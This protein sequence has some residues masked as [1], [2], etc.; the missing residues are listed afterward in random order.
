MDLSS[1]TREQI[2]AEAVEWFLQFQNPT[3]TSPDRE[4]FSNWLMRSPVHIEEY[5]AVS[6]TWVGLSIPEAPEFSTDSLIRAA[7]DSG[8]DNVVSFGEHRGPQVTLLG[9]ERPHLGRRGRGRP[10][11]TLRPWWLW[12]AASVILSIGAGMAYLSWHHDP[13]FKTATGEQRSISLSD[14]SVIFLNTNSEVRTHWTAAE[15]HVDLVKGEA[16]FQVAKDAARPFLVFTRDAS[17]RAVGTI[18]NVRSD[19]SDTE[20]AVIEGRVKVSALRRV[21]N[22]LSSRTPDA[23]AD[24]ALSS[25]NSRA[26]SIELNAGQRAAVAMNRIEPN[27]GQ[28]M[29]SVAAWTERRLVFRDQPLAAVIAEFN[30]Y[31]VQRLVV[32]DARLA[33][34]KIS[35]V[36]DSSDPDSLVAYLES[37]ET[38]RVDRPHDG[39]LHLSRTAFDS[40]LPK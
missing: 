26:P 8:P 12:L 9:A 27:A 16:R 29:D 30:R 35:G 2:A 18:F 25:G 32:D 6:S 3:R 15:R 21:A 40:D 17:V 37:F 19:Q 20:V 31:R 22:N 39:T 10:A 38:V 11:R 28:P 13:D 5:L 23:A 33:A 36:F 7:H 1:N 34:L 24:A 14:G 4:A